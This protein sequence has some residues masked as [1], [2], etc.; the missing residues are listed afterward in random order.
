MIIGVKISFPTA[1][2][3]DTFI[4]DFT[5]VAEYVR[6]HEPTTISYELLLSDKDDLHIYIMERYVNKQAYLEVHKKSSEFLSFREKFQ[7]LINGG[8]KVDG[9]SYIESNIGFV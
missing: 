8:T 3:K 9:E 2:D 1:Q 4:A 5:P 7:K 6:Q